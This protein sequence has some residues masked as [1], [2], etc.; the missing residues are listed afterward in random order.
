M[1]HHSKTNLREI[2]YNYTSFSDRE[3]VHR[4]LGADMWALLETLSTQRKTGQ[5]QRML[6]EI[7][8]DLWIVTR[9][10]IIQEAL[11]ENQKHLETFMADAYRRE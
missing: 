2:P 10:P 5:S 6:F 8:G 9:N 11:L 3:I 4:F 1:S 7:L